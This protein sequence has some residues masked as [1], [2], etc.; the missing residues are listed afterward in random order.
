MKNI[1]E[2]RGKGEK[3]ISNYFFFFYCLLRSV[4]YQSRVL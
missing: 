1:N 3:K 2:K 4:K